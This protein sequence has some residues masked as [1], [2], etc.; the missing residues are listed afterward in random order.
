MRRTSPSSSAP[1]PAVHGPSGTF[2]VS[3]LRAAL[4]SIS[5]L[6]AVDL[7]VPRL[8]IER[9]RFVLSV[10]DQASLT[11]SEINGRAA[12]RS[13]RF[14]IEVT[15]AS[16]VAHRV[17][18]KISLDPERFEGSVA[19]QCDGHRSRHAAGGGRRAGR[20]AS[21]TGWSRCARRFTADSS[22]ALRGTFEASSNTLSIASGDS[23]LDIQDSRSAGEAQWTDGGL[24]IAAAGHP[25]GGCRPCKL[26]RC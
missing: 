5:R 1:T 18:A 26:R 6:K 9:G 23:K 19:A 2:T 15:T 25:R 16:D 12:N 3:D 14:E 17:D 20:Y 11:L 24:R 4:A 10:P 8:T 13:G 7:R 22:P 21:F